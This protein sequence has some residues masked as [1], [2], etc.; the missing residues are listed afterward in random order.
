M[1]LRSYLILLEFNLEAA[2]GFEPEITVLQT[3]ALP[4]GDAAMYFSE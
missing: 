3:V 4:L 1:L 2:S